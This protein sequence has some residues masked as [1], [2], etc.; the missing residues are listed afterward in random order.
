MVPVFQMLRYH[1]LESL[2]LNG[3]Q[4]SGVVRQGGAELTVV[5]AG[6]TPQSPLVAELA[7]VAPP[8][9]EAWAPAGRQTSATSATRRTAAAAAV[10]L[11]LKDPGRDMRWFLGGF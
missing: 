4:D 11:G 8:M 5:G 3:P 2:E 10:L 9:T 7:V 6:S 1:G